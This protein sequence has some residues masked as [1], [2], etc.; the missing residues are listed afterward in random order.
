MIDLSI[1][2]IC[3]TSSGGGEGDDYRPFAVIHLSINMVESFLRDIKFAACLEA[4]DADFHNI[5]KR[6]AYCTYYENIEDALNF[7]NLVCPSENHENVRDEFVDVVYDGNWEEF[8]EG[9]IEG[10]DGTSE[11]GGDHV[12]VYSNCI[13]FEPDP[14]RVGPVETASFHL[15]EFEELLVKLNARKVLAFNEAISEQAAAYAVKERTRCI[16]LD[17]VSEAHE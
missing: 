16:Q 12:L 2:L 10:E 3:L 1:P 14:D 4:L 9:V 15:Y 13:C 5:T 8:P 17:P 6:G 11:I 7:S